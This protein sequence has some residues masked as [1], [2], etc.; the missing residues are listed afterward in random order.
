MSQC[1]LVF[2]SADDPGHK[3]IAFLGEEIA[4]EAVTSMKIVSLDDGFPD[5]ERGYFQPMINRGNSGYH[6]GN[7]V[8]NAREAFHGE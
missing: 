3:L 6:E 1:D 4:V 8:L 5:R 7:S 2:D